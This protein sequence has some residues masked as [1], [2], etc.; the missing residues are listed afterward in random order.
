MKN[1]LIK[2]WG[3][4]GTEK[5][6]YDSM[7]EI[8]KRNKKL[9]PDLGNG[10]YLYVLRN[11]NIMEPFEN[12]MKYLNRWKPKYQEKIVV[13]VDIS[14]DNDN[15]LN[16]D[17]VENQITF[18]DFYDTNEDAIKDV[19]NN[20]DKDNTFNRGN[21]D[22]LI[23]EMMLKEYGIKA[24][25]VTKETF[26]QFYSDKRRKRSNIPN[27]KEFCVRNTSII[28]NRTICSLQ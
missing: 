19:L 22:G 4:H 9:P 25:A 15:L 12:A 21:I 27:G 18:N 5:S 1:E 11:D 7:Y 13:K 8:R 14:M 26:T 10:L 6:K 24:D 28:S 20:L 2:I 16:L 17:D 3:C 23:I